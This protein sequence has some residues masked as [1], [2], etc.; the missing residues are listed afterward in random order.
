MNGN[1]AAIEQLFTKALE[2]IRT[3]NTKGDHLELYGD[4]GSLAA[5][6]EARPITK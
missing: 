1:A 3:W 2:A 4:R 6:F 5:R